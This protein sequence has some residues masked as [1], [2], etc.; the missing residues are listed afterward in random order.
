MNEHLSHGNIKT[1]NVIKPF[2]NFN[3][4]GFH[5]ISTILSKIADL[6]ALKKLNLALWTIF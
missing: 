3:L 5:K 1:Q 2:E 6:R 4:T